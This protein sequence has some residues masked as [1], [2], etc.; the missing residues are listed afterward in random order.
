MKTNLLIT[1]AV[2]I[3]FLIVF[4]VINYYK[5]KMH[6]KK[7]KNFNSLE[8]RYLT[9]SFK[10]LPEDLIKK[11]Y[12]LIVSIIDSFI[13]ALVFFI[14]EMINLNYVFRMMIGFVLLIALIYSLY[15]IYG[16]ILEK[17]YSKK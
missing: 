1:L 14:I 15:S 6:L 12:L 2:F 7:K 4:Y 3:F 8:M 11:S 10:L 5:Y 17:R 13:I 9:S 16:R